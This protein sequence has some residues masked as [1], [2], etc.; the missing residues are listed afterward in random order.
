MALMADPRWRARLAAMD[1]LPAATARAAPDRATG[2]AEAFA[3][4]RVDGVLTC[5]LVLAPLGL[6]LAEALD[7]PFLVDADDDD[8]RLLGDLGDAGT[9]AAY[10]RLARV[11]LPATAL[12]LAASSVDAEALSTRHGLG[13]RVAVVP[14]AAPTPPDPVPGPPPG[15]GRILFVGNLTYAPNVAGARWL[16]ETVLPELPD[17]MTVDLVGEAAPEVAALAG[18]RVRVHG[19]LDDLTAR[20]A[21]ADVAAAPLHHGAG[22]RIKILEAFTHRRPVVATAAAAAGLEVTDGVHLR[23]ADTPATFAEA[24]VDLAAPG[25]SA[26]LV[27]AAAD[28][29]ATTYHPGPVSRR[30]AA[31]M[32]RA[33]EQRERP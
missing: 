25:A 5:R 20:Y 17:R 18:P 31:L 11:C 16:V 24:V 26:A 19:W 1:P 29:A 6:A 22:T 21:A 27:A 10:G 15:D 3:A 2:L 30:A 33:T 12:V 23:L 32:A 9:A 14:N 13:D 4:V 7:V 8:E 28:R